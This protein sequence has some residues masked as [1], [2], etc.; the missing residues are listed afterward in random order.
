MP[1]SYHYSS[2]HNPCEFCRIRRRKCDYTIPSCGR[3]L[4]LGR[5]CIYTDDVK[6]NHQQQPSA[7]I[8][9]DSVLS[10]PVAPDSLIEVYQRLAALEEEVA[11]MRKAGTLPPLLTLT[12]SLKQQH[13]CSYSGSDTE[14]DDSISGI[15]NSTCSDSL[16]PPNELST[17]LVGGEN[18]IVDDDFITISTFYSK[19]NTVTDAAQALVNNFGWEV[20]FARSG[21][22]IHTTIHTIQDLLDFA[23]TNLQ[24]ILASEPMRSLGNI[25]E[26]DGSRMVIRTKAVEIF[27]DKLRTALNSKLVNDYAKAFNPPT[28]NALSYESTLAK[29]LIDTILELLLSTTSPLTLIIHPSVVPLLYDPHDPMSSPALCVLAACMIRIHDSNSFDSNFL[30]RLGHYTDHHDLYGHCYAL[31]NRAIDLLDESMFDEP[32]FTGFVAICLC[33]LYS[34]GTLCVKK[35]WTYRG[36]AFRMASVMIQT[37]YQGISHSSFHE[38]EVRVFPAVTIIEWETFKRT[39]WMNVMIETV[40][41]QYGIHDSAIPE[42]DLLEMVGEFPIPLDSENLQRRRMI[43]TMIAMT[44]C[45]KIALP[46][47]S[48]SDRVSLRDITESEAAVDAWYSALPADLRLATYTELT[49]AK[50]AAMHKIDNFDHGSLALSIQYHVLMIRVH[51]EFLPEFPPSPASSAPCP[52]SL[53]S[54]DIC[55]LCATLIT[56][57]YEFMSTKISLGY[58]L[59]ALLKAC[60]VHYRNTQSEDPVVRENAERNLES[61][62]NIAKLVREKMPHDLTLS[63]RNDIDKILEE[64]GLCDSLCHLYCN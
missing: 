26:D 59:P 45:M 48:S 37:R 33:A 13:H 32:N 8:S 10:A 44:E 1:N 57:L 25:S 43:N 49:P 40:L 2:R 29:S 62:L 38:G 53:R 17:R 54:R 30:D 55:T 42:H 24:L 11:I 56:A 28:L 35:A 58:F 9:Q 34:I 47:R 22:Q 4:Q 36:L 7:Q 27:V 18:I 64:L 21:F 50:I 6:P 63:V 51:E 5:Q 20:T 16:S 12:K 52:N 3:C 23:T 61:S 39:H 15:N 19:W 60:D 31:F 46:N 14:D 41:G